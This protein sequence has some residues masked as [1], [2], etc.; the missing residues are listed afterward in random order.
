MYRKPRKMFKLR[1][2]RE[3]QTKS[4]MRYWFSAFNLEKFESYTLSS[5][6]GNRYRH[7]HTPMSGILIDPTFSGK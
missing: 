1:A 2:V 6:G 5:A 3:L 4:L 7:S